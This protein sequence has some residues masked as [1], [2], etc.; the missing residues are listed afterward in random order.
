MFVLPL[1]P[2]LASAKAEGGLATVGTLHVHLKGGS[3]DVPDEGVAGWFA[4]SF[5]VFRKQTERYGVREFL[6]KYSRFLSDTT[7]RNML[8]IE[9][10]YTTV[11]YDKT[12]ANPDDL[13]TAV[14]AANDLPRQTPKRQ[15]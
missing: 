1:I 14:K 2:E 5:G 4:T 13:G 6:E 9:I 12:Q 7:L 3:V 8:L 15:Q 11:Y 10:D